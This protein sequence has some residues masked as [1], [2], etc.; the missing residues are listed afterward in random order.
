MTPRR[1][2]HVMR[3]RRWRK[4]LTFGWALCDDGVWRPYRWSDA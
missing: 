1:K 2:R 3:A 4:A